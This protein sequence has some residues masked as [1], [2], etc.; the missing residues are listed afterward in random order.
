MK[1]P[2]PTPLVDVPTGKLL[3]R[4]LRCSVTFDSNSEIKGR[5]VR[6]G[7]SMHFCYL[8]P[9]VISITVAVASECTCTP[10]CN[11]SLPFAAARNSKDDESIKFR[12][13][14]TGW[15][16][17]RRRRLDGCNITSWL[18]NQ[19]LLLLLRFAWLTSSF[20][21]ALEMVTS[22]GGSIV[23]SGDDGDDGVHV[24]ADTAL[25]KRSNLRL[26]E[27]EEVNLNYIINAE[28]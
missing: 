17:R 27:E 5:T 13:M 14:V 21:L 25:W 3:R 24:A 1:P 8:R 23:H 19:K 9:T 15:R 4:A 7:V 6:I 18:W 26:E 11:L 12:N 16:R 20:S 28:R 10:P 2:T 22:D